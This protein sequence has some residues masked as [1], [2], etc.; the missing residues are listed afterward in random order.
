MDI[1]GQLIAVK[2]QET[3]LQTI[4]TN[5]VSELV[6]Y[7]KLSKSSKFQTIT[8]NPRLQKRCPLIWAAFNQ[9]TTNFTVLMRLIDMVTYLTQRTPRVLQDLEDHYKGRE[10]KNLEVLGQ[11]I[12][13]KFHYEDYYYYHLRTQTDETN[14]LVTITEPMPAE[15][16]LGERVRVAIMVETPQGITIYQGI[17]ELMNQKDVDQKVKAE[18]LEAMNH[19]RIDGV[20]VQFHTYSNHGYNFYPLLTVTED[21]STYN[22]LLSQTSIVI[23]DAT[24]KHASETPLTEEQD[25]A[26]QQIKLLPAAEQ[27]GQLVHTLYQLYKDCRG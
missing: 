2:K 14:T 19:Y 3:N 23:Q 16:G 7:D 25:A 26:L 18:E 6:L 10:L 20:L 27:K 24:G 15:D 12:S 17:Q 5:L 13:Q 21:T 4:V 11:A 9:D 8:D 1:I 22:L